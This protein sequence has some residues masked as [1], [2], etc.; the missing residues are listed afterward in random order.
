MTQDIRNGMVELSNHDM[1]HLIGGPFRFADRC[2]IL[3]MKDDTLPPVV[4]IDDPIL[5][6]VLG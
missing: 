1:S 3:I 4:K 2:S 6:A 5:A